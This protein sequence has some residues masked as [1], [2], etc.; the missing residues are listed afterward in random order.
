[1]HYYRLRNTGTTDAPPATPPKP[2]SVDECTAVAKS[3]GL[4][5]RHYQ[6]LKTHG[7]IRPDD[8]R[9]HADRF[10]ARVNK[11]GTGCWIWTGSTT[12]G[13]GN[14]RIDGRP[15]R[16]HRYAWELL[17]GPIPAGREV[18]HTCHDSSCRAGADC[19]HRRC[20]NPAHLSIVLHVENMAPDRSSMATTAGERQRAKTHCPHGHPYS[21]DNTYINKHDGSRRCRTCDRNTHRRIRGTP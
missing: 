13:Y 18:D 15:W 9:S 7:E 5:N 20:V 3:R 16:V 10:W 4:C 8:L 6:Q 12:N 14:V 17:N 19:P 2:C 11:S 1:M 21:P